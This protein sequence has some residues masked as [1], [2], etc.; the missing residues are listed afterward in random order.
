[1]ITTSNQ[2]LGDSTK[3]AKSITKKSFLP[4]IFIILGGALLL[5]PLI[6]S[7]IKK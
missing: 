6:I 7:K 3:S 1:M 5:T 2:I 4:L